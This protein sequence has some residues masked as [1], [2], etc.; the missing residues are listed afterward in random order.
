M[1]N[2]F[3][4]EKRKIQK[5]QSRYEKLM[6]EAYQLSTINREASDKKYAEA[7]QVGKEIEALTQ[8]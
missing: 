3:N 4:S 5:L 2:L 6:K 1:F 7:D 8:Q